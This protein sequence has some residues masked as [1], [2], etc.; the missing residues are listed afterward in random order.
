MDTI[1]SRLH[2]SKAALYYYVQDKQ[3][4]LYECHRWA[5][6]LGF[7]ALA[8]AERLEARPPDKLRAAI[9]GF[10]ENVTAEMPSPAILLDGWTLKG[11]LYRRLV[12]RR[13]EYEGRLRALVEAGVTSGDFVPCDPKLTVFAMLGVVNWVPRWYSP[14]G[15]KTPKELGQMFADY[16]VRG[17]ERRGRDP[18]IDVQR[19]ENKEEP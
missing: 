2:V 15:A 7:Q 4:I 9:A 19:G 14:R 16:L 18:D 6:E 10:I 1:A 12:R 17:L 8:V 11:R 3:H 5:L 13:D